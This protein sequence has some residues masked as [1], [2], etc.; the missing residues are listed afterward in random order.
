MPMKALC[1][2]LRPS[3]HAQCHQYLLV[4][5]PLFCA[6]SPSGSLTITAGSHFLLFLCCSL[7]VFA[8]DPSDATSSCIRPQLIQQTYVPGAG[9]LVD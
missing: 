4:T 9:G 3:P 1:K 7:H 8:K 5:G 6:R 2:L